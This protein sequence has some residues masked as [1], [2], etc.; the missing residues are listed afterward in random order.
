MNKL[1]NEDVE[2]FLRR[3]RRG[4]ASL[5]IDIREDLVLEVRSHLEERSGSADFDLTE[6]FGSP[7][8]YAAAFVAEQAL[9]NA[10]AQPAPW[11]LI[12]TLFVRV[13]SATV[14]IFIVLPLAVIQISAFL[15]VVMGLVKPFSSHIGLFLMPDGAFGAFGWTN[16]IG[17]M[18]EVLGNAGVP[19]F[20]SIGLL[21]M[22]AC[23][24][25]LTGI[26]KREL[27]AIH[28]SPK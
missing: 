28:P 23:N 17:V 16:E 7:E 19:L 8:K 20:I 18:H 9:T 6:N 5:P 27:A 21:I 4:L 14:T 15:C 3:F 26:A 24:K 25:L 1:T 10:V 12:G 22:W 13:Q 2:K 11:G